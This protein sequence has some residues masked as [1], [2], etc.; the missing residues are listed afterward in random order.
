MPPQQPQDNWV[1]DDPAWEDEVNV[2]VSPMPEASPSFLESAYRHTF[3]APEFITKPASQFAEFLTPGKTPQ[4]GIMDALGAIPDVARGMYNEPMATM[5]GFLGGGVEGAASLASPANILTAGKGRLPQIANSLL[6]KAQMLHGGSEVL[7]GNIGKGLTEIGLGGFQQIPGRGKLVAPSGPKPKMKLNSDGTYTNKDTGEVFNN[8][9]QPV[10]SEITADSFGEDFWKQGGVPNPNAKPV[11]GQTMLM[12]KAKATPIAIKQAKEQGFEFEGID[13][14]GNFKF[15]QTGKVTQQPILESEVPKQGKGPE[16][17]KK[18]S[19]A[20]EMYELPR[21][22]MSVD[23]PFV[24]SAMFRQGLPLI[25]TKNW[26]KATYHQAK[27]FGSEKFYDAKTQEIYN[28]P[29]FK[30]RPLP[31]GKVGKS[32]AEEIGIK[33]TDRINVKEEALRSNLAERIPVYGKYIKA[34]NRAYTLF[35]NDLRRMELNSL[36]KAGQAV[37]KAEGNPMNDPLSNLVLGRQIGD[38]V[39]DATGRSSLKTHLPG[40]IPGY[41]KEIN[42]EKSAKILTDMMFSPRLVM[43][44]VRMLNPSTYTMA[45]PFVR[46]QYAKALVRTVGSW[47]SIASLAEMAGAQVSKDPSS[48]DYGKIKIG[49]TRLDPGGGFQQFLVLG[50]RIKP[51]AFHMPMDETGITPVDL[52]S[53]LVSTPGNQYTSSGSGTSYQL[54]Q[55]YKPE[56]R[57]SITINFLANK[58]HPTAKLLYDIGSANEQV[59]VHLGDRM[60]QLFLPMMAGDLAELAQEEPELIP[61]ILPLAGS[62]MGSQTYTGEPGEPSITPAI[63]SLFGTDLQNSDIVLGR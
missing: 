15:K 33:M 48:A 46:K 23:P 40:S 45:H 53:G 29:L 52:M 13:D 43:S 54:G 35:L 27:A 12:D 47:W 30:G 62:G 3:E 20:R 22:A 14:K 39:N 4:G 55:G 36:V 50:S 5:K 38:F 60:A 58:L 31:E 57:T 9:G 49:N 7:S 37:A 24:T 2:D 18:I 17:P 44:R 28:D 11:V 10:D 56:T 51:E 41:S 59:P 8:K 26:F 21:A 32:Y 34:S 6:G 1:D 25:G 19:L 42:L 61:L 16:T 63:D